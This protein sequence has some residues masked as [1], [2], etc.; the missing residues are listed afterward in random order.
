MRVLVLYNE[1]V[2]PADHPDADSEHEIL[3]TTDVVAGHLTEAGFDVTR[4]GVSRDPSALL[5]GLR[6]AKPEVGT[7]L[8]HRTA[9]CARCAYFRFS[10]CR[11]S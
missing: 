2:L 8:Q 1:P 7:T 5:T 3:Y 6:R 10:R 4:L 9:M 11:R